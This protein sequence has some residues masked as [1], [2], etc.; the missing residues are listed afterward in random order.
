[1]S[2]APSLLKQSSAPEAPPPLQQLMYGLIYPAVLGTGI[3]LTGV[4][5]AH[6]SSAID[7]FLIRSILLGTVA[8]LFFCAS[9]DSAFYWPDGET[10]HYTSLAFGVDFVE[11]ILMFICFHYLRLF[12]DPARL[13]APF[14][15][16]A[17]MALMADVLLQFIWRSVVG[18]NWRHKWLLR[19]SV[20]AVLLIGSL[21]GHHFPWVNVAVSFAVGVSVVVYVI[22]D[23]RYK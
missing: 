3:V 13:L 21:F 12:E 20:A 17:Y 18:L 1:M 14:L 7:A 22:A 4:R 19:T 8:G 2:D 9:F 16:A 10:G 23:P 6:H 11:V 15:P 5:A